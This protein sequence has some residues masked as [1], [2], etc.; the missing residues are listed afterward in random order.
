MSSDVAMSDA[1]PPPSG[2]NSPIE[3]EQLA[4]LQAKTAAEQSHPE[5]LRHATSEEKVEAEKLKEEGNKKFAEFRFAAA[6]DFY[7]KAVEKDPHNPVYYSNRAFCDL[8]LE[9]YGSALIDA[10]KAIELDRTFIKAYYRRGAAHL[11]LAKYKEARLDFKTVVKLKPTDKD[12]QT[13]LKECEKA[14]YAA[15][16]SKAIEG[17]KTRPASETALLKLKDM[18]IEDSYSGPKYV[19]GE[20][21]ISFVT[22]LMEYFKSQKKLPRKMVYQILLDIITLFKTLPT[23]LDIDIAPEKKFTVCGD[24]HGQFWDV[25]NIFQL[26]GLPG[27]ENPYLF[28]GDFVD[29]GSFSLEVIML[30]FSFKLCF[31]LHFHMLRGNHETISM[32]SVYGFQGEVIAKVETAIFELFTE[33]FNLIPLAACLQKK[34]LVVHGGLFSDDNVTLDQI[35]AINRNQQPPESGLMTE[36]LVSGRGTRDR[37]VDGSLSE[38]T[39]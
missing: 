39:R 10:D 5:F 6:R 1:H 31:P 13:K 25:C 3:S 7:T 32:N 21:T 38:I 34:V 26:N 19:S 23:L 30:F 20:V 28:N 17:E 4:E 14:I 11:A 18:V 8:K 24:V 15:A 9:E 27:P 36:L 16:F 35:R 33:A 22:E 12:A 37:Q 2:G 29:R